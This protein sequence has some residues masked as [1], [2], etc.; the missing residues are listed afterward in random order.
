MRGKSLIVSSI[1]TQ[2]RI[3]PQ[4]SDLNEFKQQVIDIRTKKSITIQ[5]EVM[6][7]RQEVEIA[8]FLYLNNI[9]YEYEPNV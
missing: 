2:N 3:L 8:N 6:R 5:S 1:K 4:R 7:S 9:D